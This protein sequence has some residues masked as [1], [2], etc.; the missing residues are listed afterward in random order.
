MEP[1]PVTVEG[2][3]DS[4]D[5]TS[6]SVSTE[7][8]PEEFEPLNEDELEELEVDDV[9]TTPAPENRDEFERRVSRL[10]EMMEND[11]K[12]RDRILAETYVNIASAEQGIR[13][14]FEMVQSQGMAGF[15]RGMFRRKE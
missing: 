13:G 14:V 4:E 15:A 3:T 12:V 6:E 2:G 8:P 10:M 5:E 9:L 1:L 7:S 11:P